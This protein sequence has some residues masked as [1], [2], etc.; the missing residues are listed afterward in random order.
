MVP[1]SLFKAGLDEFQ[2]ALQVRDEDRPRVQSWLE[3][4]LVQAATQKP[5]AWSAQFRPKLVALSKTID[6][7]FDRQRA[8][9]V[10]VCD[11][12][13]SDTLTYLTRGTMWFDGIDQIESELVRVISSAKP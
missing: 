4:W 13:D 2:K 5:G 11:S 6:L 12:A 7:K 10:V 9:F 8:K 1:Q 3:Q